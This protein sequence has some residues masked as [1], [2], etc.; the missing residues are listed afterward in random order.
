MKKKK[1]GDDRFFLNIVIFFSYKFDKITIYKIMKAFFWHKEKKTGE[2]LVYFNK[3]V[4][5]L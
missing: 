4:F 3:G 5:R 2:V 1:T